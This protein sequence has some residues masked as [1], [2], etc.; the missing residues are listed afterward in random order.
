MY[1]PL[2]RS[3]SLLTLVAF[4]LTA[5]AA[6][7]G[8][9]DSNQVPAGAKWV[10]HFDGQAMKTSDPGKLIRA[11]M[12][13]NEKVKAKLAAMSEKIGMDPS[14]DLVD[15]TLYNTDFQ[16]DRGVILIEVAK[17]DGQ[18]AL[19]SLRKKH[20]EVRMSTYDGN[21]LFTWKMPHAKGG[22]DYITSTLVNGSTIVMSSELPKVME[23]IDVLSGKLPGLSKSSPLAAEA[24][25]GTIVLMRGTDMAGADLPGK[26]PVLKKAEGF[27]FVAGQD[28]ENLFANTMLIAESED[29]A[30]KLTAIVNGFAALGAMRFAD[31]KEMTALISGLKTTADGKVLSMNWSG[32][33]AE[34]M[35]AMMKMKKHFHGRHGK[36]HKHGW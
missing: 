22:Q 34:T 13:G 10:M 6:T 4:V 1:R 29:V 31:D 15:V 17:I 11:K 30:K 27:S 5:S 25:A 33:S 24:P 28:G 14:E 18:K 3:L 16:R 7:A 20:P 12:L 9:F 23:A 32:N 21:K 8:S 19:A 35:K 36:H 26:C 2:A